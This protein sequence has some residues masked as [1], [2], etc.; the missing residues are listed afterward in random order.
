[1][2]SKPN[3]KDICP[4]WSVNSKKCRVCDD[5]LFIP[6]EKHIAAYCTSKDHPHCLQYS[7]HAP[8]DQGAASQSANRRQTLRIKLSNQIQLLK[9]ITSGQVIRQLT[10]KA[11]TLDVS[12]IGMRLQTDIPLVH[13]SVVQ[14][15]FNDKFPSTLKKGVGVV[16][17]CNKQ[18][19]SPGYQAGISFQSSKLVKA[20]DTF[21]KTHLMCL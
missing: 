16:E 8:K 13:D 10:G 1:M 18:I 12:H 3:N 9:L 5:G 19:D 2:S 17:W 20:M 14:F 21:L 6:L 7:L 4:F 15:A 11:E